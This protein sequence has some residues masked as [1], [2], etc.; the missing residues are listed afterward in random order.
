M[1]LQCLWLVMLSS[2]VVYSCAV[3]QA[4]V[5]LTSCLEGCQNAITL[6][7]QLGAGY[8]FFCGMM[9]IVQAL[10]LPQKMEKAIRPFLQWIMPHVS[11]TK[12]K[13][14]VCMNLSA[15]LLGIGNAATPMGIEA[16]HLMDDEAK[17]N[18]AIRHS[19][20][21]FLIVN[22]TSIQLLPTTILTLRIAA[23]SNQPSAVIVPNMLCTAL[24]TT[25]GIGL[26]LLCRR[27]INVERIKPAHEC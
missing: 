13:Q 4:N 19:M 22:A 16:M 27:F 21:M 3:G 14:A 20:M 15:N 7:L 23:G 26:A 6:T 9:E 12:T 5:V 11:K 18:P 25:V 8:L 17:H 10:A 24:S 2:S 1:L